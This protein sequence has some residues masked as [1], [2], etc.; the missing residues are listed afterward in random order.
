MLVAVCL[1]SLATACVSSDS[2]DPATA[3]CDAEACDAFVRTCELAPPGIAPACFGAPSG[4]GDW[5]M[6]ACQSACKALK[7]GETYQC[8]LENRSLCIQAMGCGEDASCAAAARDELQ[9][10][11]TPDLFLAPNTDCGRAC[12]NTFQACVAAC[13]TAL[14]ESCADCSVACVQAFG[15]CQDAC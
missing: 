5:G 7:L 13:P 14:L 1:G 9:T 12:G 2:E 10:R 6:T 4:E 15:D 11:C 3:G 8:V